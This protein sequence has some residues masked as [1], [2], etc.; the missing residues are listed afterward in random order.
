VLQVQPIAVRIGRRGCA[1]SSPDDTLRLAPGAA[2]VVNLGFRVGPDCPRHALVS[3]RVSFDAG[4]AGILHA[5]SSQLANFE[6]LS[7]VQCA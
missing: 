6:K 7:F 5:D 2:A 4:T 3:A 1:S